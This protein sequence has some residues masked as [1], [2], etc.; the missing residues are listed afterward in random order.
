MEVVEEEEAGVAEERVTGSGR[1]A[2]VLSTGGW[3]RSVPAGRMLICVL[4]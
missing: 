4:A 3:E 1:G 2:G